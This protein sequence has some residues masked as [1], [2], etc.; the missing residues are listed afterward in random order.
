M[1]KYYDRIF[2]HKDYGKEADFLDLI[3]KKFGKNIKD[4][5]DIAC[6]TATHALLL[7]S[8]GYQIVGC[9]L[10]KDM[11][12]EARKKIKKQK[13]KIKVFH[14]DMRDI[15]T[16]KKFDAAI[17]M[18]TS[19]HYLL[20]EEDMVKSL[21][22]AY[23]VLKT[24][25]LYILDLANFI[26]ISK[27]FEKVRGEAFYKDKKTK[28]FVLAIND[29]DL[30]KKIH[31]MRWVYFI[32]DKGKFSF[33]LDETKLRIIEPNEM[34]KLLNKVGFKIL[35]IYGDYDLKHKFN[36]NKSKRMIFVSRK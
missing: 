20:T 21:R 12:K 36:L 30:K 9:D 31:T 18:F 14:S 1:A 13:S 29:Q 32:E 11:L 34:K 17:C 22:A 16:D 15:R 35:E 2:A 19:F 3:F 7:E 4:I 25:G 10:S 33:N 28:I 26:G 27:H 6:G 8:K 5:L 24:N 23:K